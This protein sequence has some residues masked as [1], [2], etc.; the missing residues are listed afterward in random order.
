MKPPLFHYVLGMFVFAC[1]ATGGDPSSNE[2]DGDGDTAG[3]GD[4]DV[5]P[6]SGGVVGDGDTAPNTG[7]AIG[8]GDGSPATGGVLGD[9]DLGTGGDPGSDG[10]TPNPS[11]NSVDQGDGTFVDERTCLMWMKE[12]WPNAGDSLTGRE[13]AASCSGATTA[14]HSDWRGPDAAEMVSLLRLDGAT[15]AMWNSPNLWDSQLNTS[16]MNE[17]VMFYTATEGDGMGSEHQCALNGNN[18]ELNGS[19]RLNAGWGVVCVRGTS[20]ITGT[21]GSCVGTACDYQ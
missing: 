17:P 8:D 21:I 11:G 12:P 4:G 5:T 13:H 9:G 1:S 14:G 20:P 3:D 19:T 18:A 2:G 6:G 15:C 7:G 16:A 10:C